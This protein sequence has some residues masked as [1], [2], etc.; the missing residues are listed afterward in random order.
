MSIVSFPTPNHQGIC[1]DA[2][3]ITIRL[4]QVFVSVFFVSQSLPFGLSI[5]PSTVYH[6]SAHF[7]KCF[8]TFSY[9]DFSLKAPYET[10]TVRILQPMLA[11]FSFLSRILPVHD[12][13]PFW[14]TLSSRYL[15]P[16]MIIAVSRPPLPQPVSMQIIPLAGNGSH[17]PSGRSSVVFS[18]PL[19]QVGK[20]S[21]MCPTTVSGPAYLFLKTTS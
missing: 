14:S 21:A 10:D 7:F 1:A 2:A 13:T 3:Q 8:Q 20:S 12:H 18:S 11:A 16:S 6:R 5:H 17:S 19:N 15:F 9:P 4:G